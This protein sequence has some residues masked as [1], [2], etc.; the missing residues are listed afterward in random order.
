[1]ALQL[2]LKERMSGWIEFRGEGLPAGRHPFV[3]SVDA[4]TSDILRFGATRSCTGTVEFG[5]FHPPVPVQGELVLQLGGPSYD[6]HFR[7]QGI[8]DVHVAGR[9]TY[10]LRRLIPSMTTLPLLVY[11][12][13]QII[14]EAELVYR[15]SVLAFPLKALRLRLS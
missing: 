4:A 14:G 8:G 1:M 15:D 13:G 10:D 5:G 11:R 6:M 3:F 7:L 9:K 12:D 2:V